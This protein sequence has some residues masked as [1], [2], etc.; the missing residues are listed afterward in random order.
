VPFSKKEIGFIF[1]FV[2]DYA[3]RN[4]S[5]P[6]QYFF[7]SYLFPNRVKYYLKSQKSPSFFKNAEEK[8]CNEDVNPASVL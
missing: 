2:L 5:M 6:Q 1:L 7:C 3:S 4:C 8:F